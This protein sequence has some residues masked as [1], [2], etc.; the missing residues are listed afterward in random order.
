[1]TPAPGELS[2]EFLEEHAATILD[3]TADGIFTVD[4]RWKIT[5]FNHAA[6]RITGIPRDE[7]LGRT[8]CDVFRASICEA[9]CALRRTIDTGEP[10]VGKA[11]YIVD[12]QGRRIP[13]SISTAVL[14]DEQGRFR[15]GVETFRDLTLIQ[16]L[17]KELSGQYSFADI[18]GKSHRMQDLFAVLPQ[19]AV[20]GSTT[21]IEGETG[22]GKE[23]FARAVHSL[24]SRRSGPFVVA[25]CAALPETLLESELFGFKRGAFTGAHK[26][27]PG[28]FAL[29]RGGTIFLDEVG[30]MAPAL[31]VRLLRVLQ[32]KTIEPLGGTGVEETDAR[33]VLATNR[34]LEDLVARGEFREDLFYRVN[35]VRL[36]L[37]PLRER[38]EDIPLLVEHFVDRFNRLQEKDVGGISPEAMA[39]L[40]GHDFPG[41]V[42]ELE[43]LVERAFVLKRG[44]VIEPADLP[45]AL[46]PE[47]GGG[48]DVASGP[49]SLRDLER[50]AIVA[51]LER[52]RWHRLAAAE[53]LGIHKTTLFRKIAAYGI[54]LPSTDGRSHPR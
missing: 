9:D 41:N 32:E 48:E 44:G 38:R 23:L 42:R 50:Q 54:E 3:S 31:Q 6:E 14:R 5:S 16:E 1:M 19:I 15:G 7:A 13:I 26:D 45:P 29:A 34:S 43:N 11:V 30:D 37:P 21:L 8:C 28:R 39:L 20:S 22:T 2:A 51:A 46:R 53:E 40:V 4:P 36:E 25:N 10:V 52:N 17:R 35:V 47:E 49:L 24:S 12:A 18:I 27:K 33:V